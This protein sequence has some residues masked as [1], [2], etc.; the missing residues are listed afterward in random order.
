MMHSMINMIYEL[1]KSCIMHNFSFYYW[2]KKSYNRI[3]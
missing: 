1:C 3:K 2:V